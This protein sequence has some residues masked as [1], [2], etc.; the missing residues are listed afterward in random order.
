MITSATAATAMSLCGG[1]SRGACFLRRLDVR[2]FC[3]GSSSFLRGWL[4]RQRFGRS[5]A[6]CNIGQIGRNWGRGNLRSNS[7]AKTRGT[8]LRLGLPIGT[9]EA[10]GRGHVPLA[11]ILGVAIGFEIAR[12]LKGHHGVPRFQK[13]G[14]EL[15]RG[16]LAGPCSS[17]SCGDLF[18]IGHTVMAF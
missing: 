13:Q 11:G 9:T 3:R 18:P 7:G 15:P 10:L 4:W 14:R 1:R 17:D 12:Q 5:L 2:H 6:Y 8:F 16:V